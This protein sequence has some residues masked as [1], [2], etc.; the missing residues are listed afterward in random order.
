[1]KKVSPHFVQ[2]AQDACLKSFWRKRTLCTFLRQHHITEG[3]LASWAEYETKR[4][5]LSRL[6]DKL[7]SL[8]DDRAQN[9]ILDV[10][11]SLA[12]QEHFPDLENWE[13]SEKKTAEARE[14][15][16]RLRKEVARID[17]QQRDEVESQ[18]R[19]TEAEKR[20]NTTLAAM[21]TLE[22]L[23][24]RLDEMATRIGMQDAGYEFEV[25][26]YDLADYFEIE[27]RRPY[28]TGGR[29][30]DG[31][32]TMEGT[33]YLV[34]LKF[35]K[36]PTDAADI[37]VFRRK[38]TSKADNTMGLCVSMSGFTSTAKDAA[39][40]ERTPLLLLDY[41]HLYFVLSSTMTLPEVISRIKRHAAQTAVAYLPIGDFSR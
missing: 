9:L 28:K 7:V 32:I 11:H 15:V 17:E 41:Q 8:K 1:M 14:A 13:D 40:G 5:F 21:Q 35:T 23:K 16:A 36:D 3:V 10:A 37:D 39:S 6:F 22:K 31:S 20:R 4:D 24:S 19:R 26:F 25:W 2:L 27:C 33:T 12:V 18:R 38:V 34:E 30:I 29:Q